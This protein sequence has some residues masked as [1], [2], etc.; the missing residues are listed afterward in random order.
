MKPDSTSVLYW[1]R[2][3]A[4][5]ACVL[6]V[7]MATGMLAEVPVR[8]FGLWEH[9]WIGIACACTWVLTAYVVAPDKKRVAA[10]VFFFAGTLL[11]WKL[12]GHSW[13]PEG[14]PKAYQPSRLPFTFACTAGLLTLWLLIMREKRKADRASRAPSEPAPN[15]DSS[16]HDR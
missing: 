4:L 15:A 14:S 8:L 10:T 3:F 13:Y 5:P 11:A 1:F 2:W 16:A 9:L 6:A 12:V 7:F